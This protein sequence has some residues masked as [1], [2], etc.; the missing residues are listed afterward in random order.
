MLQE[1]NVPL[2]AKQQERNVLRV[3]KDAKRVPLA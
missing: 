3:G 2:V 1:R